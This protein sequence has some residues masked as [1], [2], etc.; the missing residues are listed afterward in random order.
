[1]TAGGVR[2]KRA[3]LAF[4]LRFFDRSLL[5]CFVRLTG[6]FGQVFQ[7]G[8]EA[9]FGIVRTGL[10]GRFPKLLDL[11]LFRHERARCRKL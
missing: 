9:F 11:G 1:M 4:G 7:R 6:R 10:F 3:R 8:V 5:A 2:G